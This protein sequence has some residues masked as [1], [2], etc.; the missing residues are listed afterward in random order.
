MPTA[1][2]KHVAAIGMLKGINTVGWHATIQ[3][4]AFYNVIESSQLLPEISN[5]ML[6][7]SINIQAAC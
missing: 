6:I 4:S 7:S 3:L 1:E 5:G 2:I